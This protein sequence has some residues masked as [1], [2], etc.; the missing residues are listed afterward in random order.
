VQLAKLHADKKNISVGFIGEWRGGR[1]GGGGGGRGRGGEGAGACVWRACAR[2]ASAPSLLSPVP[3]PP[4]RP[5]A[6][7][8]NTG[9][10]SIINSLK[11][12]KVCSVAPIPGETKVWQYVTLMKRVFLIDCPGVVYDTGDIRGGH[13]A[14]GRRSRGGVPVGPHSDAPPSLWQGVVRPAASRRPSDYMRAP[15]SSAS[16]RRT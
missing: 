13:R 14:Q 8:P 15:S 6:G 12:K 4:P 16:S 11:S 3:R 1:G 9:K 5:P 2:R 10:S 7:Y